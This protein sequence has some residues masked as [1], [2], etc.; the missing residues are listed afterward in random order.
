MYPFNF[1]I[2][3]QFYIINLAIHIS[4]FNFDM[5][6]FEDTKGIIRSR[7]LQKDKQ[8]N[9]QKKRDKAM[10]YKTLSVKL[11]IEQHQPHR[12][13]TQVLQTGRQFLLNMWHPL[14]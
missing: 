2:C 11:K 7:K 1:Y 3:F 10:I 4:L 8:H 9:G 5:K 13:W 14:W 12:G 6:S